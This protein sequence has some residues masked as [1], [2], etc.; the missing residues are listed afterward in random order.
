[1]KYGVR[2]ICDVVLRAKS[3]QTLGKST[4]TKDM[5]VLYFDSLKTSS[6]EGAATTVYAEGG[7]G[8]SRLIAWE[9]EKTIT[10]TMEDA[11]ISPVGLAV[12]SGAG[13]IESLQD[14][15]D[16]AIFHA[17]ETAAVTVVE[18]GSPQVTLTHM[19]IGAHNDTEETVEEKTDKDGY[20]TRFYTYVI[21]LDSQGDIKGQP[22]RCTIYQKTGE[23]KGKKNNENSPFE[24]ILDK[25]AFASTGLEALKDG[26]LVMIDYYYI[27]KGQSV[28]QIDIDASHFAGNYY[29]EASTLWRNKLGEDKPAEFIIPNC[30]IQSNFT[31]SMAATGD[32]STFT[33]T[34]DAFPDYTK[35]DSSHKVLCSIR[36]MEE[37]GTKTEEISHKDMEVVGSAAAAAYRRPRKSSIST[38]TITSI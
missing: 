2:E 1:M 16:G 17:T 29:L 19:P 18:T 4:F 15:K 26:D 25:T 7:H 27:G 11:L 33:F 37:D 36:V 30:K 13:L 8:N 12:L 5:P 22:V 35:Y 32:P 28:T 31:F 20:A 10:F 21:P 34:M 3:T 38:D 23:G 9:G 14:N 24:G 6:L